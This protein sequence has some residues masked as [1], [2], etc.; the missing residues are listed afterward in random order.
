MGAG[1]DHS[2]KPGAS[3]P[4]A[5]PG[6][7]LAGNAELIASLLCGALLGLGFAIE[8][9]AAGAPG[10]IAL[11]AY[12][13]AYAL[14]GWFTAREAVEK[15]RRRKFEIDSLMLVAAIGA[16]S[17]GAWAEGALLLFLFSLGHAL[18][19]YAMGRA[20]KAI[21]ALAALAPTIARVRQGEDL[22]E[23]PVEAVV[24]GDIVVVR[25]NERLPAD[26]FVIKGVS[27]VDQ[28]P[29]TGESVP[30]D[31][32][33]VEDAA[34]ARERPNGVEAASKVFAGTINGEGAIEVEVTKLSSQ[35]ALARV[36]QMVSEAET[37]KSPTQRFTDQF[38]RVFVPV[39]LITVC[40]LLTP[41]VFIDEPF[42][43][44]FYRAMAVL[45]AASPCALA[46]ATPSA[47]LSGVA[48]AA[49]GGVLIKGGAPLENLG[50]LRAIAFDKT[51]TLTE[52]RPRITDVVVTGA[53]GEEE[54]LQVAVAVEQLS[55]HPLA[56]AIARDG[57]ERLGGGAIAQAQDLKSLTG[58][59]VTARLNG[60]GV[61]IGKAEMFGV[62]GLAP[63]DA[64]TAE[65]ISELRDKGRTTMVVRLGD[66]DLGVI[67][68]L[69][70]PRPGAKPALAQLRALGVTRMIMI[71]GDHKK[72]ADAVAAEVGL[73]EAWGD[74]M[75]EDKVE[76]IRKLSAQDKVAMVGDGVNDA[77]AMASATVGVAMGAA[78][79]DVALEAADVALMADD[80]ARLP[81][82]VG[83]S[84]KTR[85]I[86]R[87]NLF[88]S[89]GVVAL[90]VP[91]TI[92]GLGIGPAVAVHEGSTLL[93]VINALRLLAYREAPS[94]AAVA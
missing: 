74:L 73:D 42:S 77:P 53:G 43:K 70:T 12:V 94:R 5:E 69:D 2:A 41:G 58:R 16:A 62:E 90:L 55:D 72:V 26:G 46:I 37:Q 22:I 88:V 50:A 18:E 11:C 35:S 45:V 79:S 85:W 9:L 44:T 57:R 86:V 48:R 54:L 23:T 15:L 36:V 56:A 6:G 93:V 91:A 47:V 13:G 10:W 49:R 17:L 39:V 59:G 33:P 89:L 60:Q 92:L 71:S 30:V 65:A 3:T 84:R 83:L 76:A 68:L 63:L 78:G 21:E 7:L 38:E 81:F 67:G 66:R 29:I 80:L 19:H 32:R 4:H 28:A 14:G 25:P 20:R 34:S 8:K 51:G 52:G 31:K 82:V 75:P 24:V 27:S 64:P 61:W 1:H 40:L 87:Q